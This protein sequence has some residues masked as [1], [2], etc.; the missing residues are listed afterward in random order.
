MV[1]LPQKQRPAHPKVAGELQG[2]AYG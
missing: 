2:I 1:R